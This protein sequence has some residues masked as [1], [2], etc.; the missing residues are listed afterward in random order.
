[1]DAPVIRTKSL[2]KVYGEGPASVAALDGVDIE[3]MAGEFVSIM[4]ASG[5][6]KTTLL[7]VLGC[8]HRPT[9]GVYEL[10]GVDVS[11]LDD[12]SMSAVR[13]RKLGFVFQSYNLLPQADIVDNAALPLVYAGVP[14]AERRRRAAA[15]LAA[16]GLGDRLRHKPGELSGGQCQRV[17]I[18]RAMVTRP[19]LLLADEPTGNLDSR[20]GVEI[21]GI[22]QKLNGIGATIVQVTHDPEKIRYSTRI[23]R[24]RDGRVE[25]VETVR[26][27]LKAA[28]PDVDIEMLPPP[29]RA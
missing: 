1:M 2:R 10:E 20:T 4:G 5:S 23:I 6:G 14:P 3:V 22:F 8:L 16:L 24:L 26:E 25:S 12:E 17:A 11:S 13:N 21:M 18:A 28:A 15:V 19:S 29:G 7:H 9:S 27:P